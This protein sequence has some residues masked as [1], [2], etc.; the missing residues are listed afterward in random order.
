MDPAIV[1]VAFDFD[2]ERKNGGDGWRSGRKR[3][4]GERLRGE[5][6]EFWKAV[7]IRQ[8]SRVNQSVS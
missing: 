6:E 7:L 5:R 1:V 3:Q 8:N 2:T 4:E